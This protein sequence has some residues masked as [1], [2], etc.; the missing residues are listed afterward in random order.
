MDKMQFNIETKKHQQPKYFYLIIV[1]RETRVAQYFRYE[2]VELCQ[3]L[4]PDKA[5]EKCVLSTVSLT[6]R[7]CVSLTM[8]I[9][10]TTEPWSKGHGLRAAIAML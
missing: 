1:M 10:P 4:F 9:S 8:I 3:E 7:N 2:G 5:S 6:Q